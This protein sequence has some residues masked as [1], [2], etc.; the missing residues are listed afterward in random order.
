MKPWIT[1]VLLMLA[2]GAGHA[3]TFELS[4]P[5]NEILAE[6]LAEEEQRAQEATAGA[7]ESPASDV[8]ADLFCTVDPVT[9]RCVCIA[10]DNVSVVETPEAECRANAGHPAL[11]D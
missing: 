8:Q 9:D 7:E 2:A 4:D 3:G 5:A 11:S 1:I 10:R 6:K